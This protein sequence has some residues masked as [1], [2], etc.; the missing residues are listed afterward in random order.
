MVG[1]AGNRRAIVPIKI[2][3]AW[4]D[5]VGGEEESR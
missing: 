1:G 2:D 4:E 5:A 3:R